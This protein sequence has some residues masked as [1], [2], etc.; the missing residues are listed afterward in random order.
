MFR[1]LRMLRVARLIM[2]VALVENLLVE[3]AERLRVRF[4]VGLI[5]TLITV[6]VMFSFNHI[7][8]CFLAA[9]G[10]PR[11]RAGPPLRQHH[12]PYLSL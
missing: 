4:L 11:P 12:N 10:S 6:A 1:I 7:L 8:T 5:P 9:V 2:L 3:Y